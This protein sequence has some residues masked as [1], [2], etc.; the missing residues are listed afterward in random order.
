MNDRFRRSIPAFSLICS[1]IQHGGVHDPASGGRPT[2]RL[3]DTVQ[4]VFA[5]DYRLEVGVGEIHEVHFWRS[6]FSG[7]VRISVD[8]EVRVR[9]L[10]LSWVGRT[11]TWDLTVGSTE[12]HKV[13]FV[14]RKALFAPARLSH[15]VHVEVDGVEVA[16]FPSSA[17]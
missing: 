14:R 3:T 13:A 2:N 5:S 9:K 1:S 6:G 4:R 16:M 8:G 12:R 15:P 10:D 17:S 7:R 11:R